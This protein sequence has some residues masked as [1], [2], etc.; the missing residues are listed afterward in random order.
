[1]SKTAQDYVVYACPACGKRV[2]A[3]RSDCGRTGRCPLC[4]HPHTVGG[5]VEAELGVER[6]GARRVEPRDGQVALEP[7]DAAPLQPRARVCSVLDL[8]E[9][10]VAFLFPGL[11]SSRHVSGYAPPDLAPGTELRLQLQAA[12]L[13]PL[14]LGAVVR[15]VVPTDDPRRWRVGMAFVGVDGEQ[16]LALSAAIRRATQDAD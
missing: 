14:W 6:R 1:M 4:R 9:S 5:P 11:P 10:G 2:F 7:G 15:R 12:G 3:P 16:R 13:Q 8:S